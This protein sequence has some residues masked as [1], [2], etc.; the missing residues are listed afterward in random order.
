MKDTDTDQ[1]QDNKALHPTAYGFV[2][3]FSLLRFRRV[4]LVVLPV[5]GVFVSQEHDST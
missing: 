3:H 5:R 4:S 1:Q 2:H